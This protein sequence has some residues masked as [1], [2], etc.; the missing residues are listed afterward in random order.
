MAG[1]GGDG[2][3]EEL[4]REIPDEILLHLPSRPTLVRRAAASSGFR[5][6]TATATQAVSCG[7]D[8]D[9]GARGVST[10]QGQGKL[11]RATC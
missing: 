5:G 10:G 4:A 11:G 2:K 7:N 3:G 8:G 1:V 9:G 6:L